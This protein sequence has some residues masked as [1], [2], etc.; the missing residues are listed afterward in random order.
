MQECINIKLIS[1][2]L[3]YYYKDKSQLTTAHPPEIIYVY[4]YGAN[5]TTAA[6]LVLNI[7]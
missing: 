7:C 5:I 4:I 6:F 1:A 2:S 3:L